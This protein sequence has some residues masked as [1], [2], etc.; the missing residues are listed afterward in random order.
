MPLV[1]HWSGVIEYNGHGQPHA[2]AMSK[3]FVG[4]VPL[5]PGS[6]VV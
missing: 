3:L 4:V 2:D 5:Q 6:A 1:D